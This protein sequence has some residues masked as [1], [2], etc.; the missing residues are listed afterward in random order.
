MN[1]R[2][3]LGPA[4]LSDDELRAIVAEWFGEPAGSVTLL[5][6]HAEVVDY[7][8]ESI[9]TAGRYWV[10]GTA[11]TPAGDR[12]FRFFVKHVQSWSR[13]PLFAN[14]PP[15]FREAAE[16]SVPWQTEPLVYASD[17]AD[18]LPE[19]L[20]MA[21]VAAMR[22]LDDLSAALWLEA[23]PTT[24]HCWTL[25]EFT[26]AARLLGRLA[27][28]QRVWPVASIGEA[29]MRRGVESYVDGRLAVQI[30][31]MLQAEE[32]WTQPL[33]A[34]TFDHA[35]RT[36][37]RAALDRLP[38]YLHELARVPLGTAHGD[39]CPNNLLVRDPGS[40]REVGG[41]FVLIDYGFWST[42]RLG[43]DLSQLLL[44]DIQIGRRPASELAAIEAVIV[45]AYLEG[46]RAEGCNL[47]EEV[48]ERSHALLMLIFSGLSAVPFDLIGAEI[49]PELVH[50]AHNRAEVA[51][52][53]LARIV[54]TTP[55][56]H[57]THPLANTGPRAP[58]TGPEPFAAPIRPDIV[59]AE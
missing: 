12:R 11:R 42:Q 19:G 48:I 51:R 13:S 20:S 3:V 1:D 30:A 52:F 9:T 14:V 43:F 37:L 8:Q 46:L 41:G 56:T 26:G 50:L 6:A 18:R 24:Q 28:S 40:R 31:P 4:D 27:A 58:V 15:E 54:A 10:S 45:P 2:A 39:A 16:R 22:D 7:A 29:T 32:V 23:V 5:E 47:A 21:R 17:L 25:Q 49:T 57:D 55:I 33:V 34:A 35:L 44:G 59:E 53:S 38:D 36:Q